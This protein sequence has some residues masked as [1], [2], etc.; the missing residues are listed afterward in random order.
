MDRDR[1]LTEPTTADPA[2][3]SSE[4]ATPRG[5]DREPS[6]AERGPRDEPEIVED[7]ARED[8]PSSDRSGPAPAERPAADA[9]TPAKAQE[10]TTTLFPHDDR[11]SY[12]NRW[13]NIQ[14]GFVDEP[15]RAV[16][17]ADA[18]VADVMQRLTESF[19]SARA[20]LEQQWDQGDHVSTEDLRVA[21]TRYRS[22]FER[23]LA[24]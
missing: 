12:Q 19:A 7:E 15:R 23:L 1:D 20:E 24:S 13:K 9:E 6:S 2:S 18:L 4:E 21:L 8:G 17:Q 3:R 14:A 16:E 22:F 11:D 5:A 10:E